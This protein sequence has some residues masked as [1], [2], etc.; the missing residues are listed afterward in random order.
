VAIWKERYHELCYENKAYFDIQR[1]HKYYDV[2]TNKFVDVIGFKDEG[3]ATWTEKYLLWGIPQ[4]EIDN[5]TKI[6]QNPG[7]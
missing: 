4:R 2:K 6:K 7:W 5:N 3:G 1:T